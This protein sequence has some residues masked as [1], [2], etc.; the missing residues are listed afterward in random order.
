M[1]IEDLLLETPEGIE[2][3]AEPLSFLKKISHEGKEILKAPS[4]QP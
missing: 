1:G 4:L 2:T 3:D